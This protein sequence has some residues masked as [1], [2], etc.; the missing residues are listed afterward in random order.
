[1]KYYCSWVG[2]GAILLVIILV[3]FQFL[4]TWQN[5]NS[6]GGHGQAHVM[7]WVGMGGH[8]S[9]LMGVVWV[10]VQIRKK[11]WALHYSTLTSG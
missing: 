2:M 7:L 11:C 5:L 6:M 9:I 3:M 10:W 4:N 8:R 1:M